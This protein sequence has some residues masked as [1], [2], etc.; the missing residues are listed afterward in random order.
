MH[1]H[2]SCMCGRDCRYLTTPLGVA[3]PA[4]PQAITSNSPDTV[5]LTAFAGWDDVDAEAASVA[6]GQA[7]VVLASV[8]TYTS[9]SDHMEHAFGV[10]GN[11]GVTLTHAG[12]VNMEWPNGYWHG[13]V[14]IPVGSGGKYRTDVNDG[15]N[16]GNTISDVVVSEYGH[17]GDGV[18][19]LAE[20]VVIT[21]Q[22]TSD[23]HVESDVDPGVPTTATAVIASV[24]T[25]ATQ[26]D[27]FLVGFGRPPSDGSPLSCTLWGHLPYSGVVA[28]DVCVGVGV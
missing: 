18:Q 8:F 21:L 11:M 13:T 24:T 28:D 14:L 27:M 22:A 25:H 5:S 9:V 20:P 4:L 23:C 3:S 1:A 7:R 6:R 19:V 2:T 12:D 17:L 16:D 26:S 10:E 15:I